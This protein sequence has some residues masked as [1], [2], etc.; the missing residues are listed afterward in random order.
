MLI[1]SVRAL[2]TCAAATSIALLQTAM[3]HN[4]LCGGQCHSQCCCHQFSY[5]HAAVLP[6]IAHEVQLRIR[7][8]CPASFQPQILLDLSQHQKES[9][10]MV[11][12]YPLLDA[13]VPPIVVASRVLE[14]FA[15]Q[16]RDTMTN[17]VPTT[18]LAAIRLDRYCFQALNRI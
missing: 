15:I 2:C 9:F 16:V 3:Q 8:I 6:M 17:I 13:R 10:P 5:S 7:V 11:V 14:I 4:Y 18:P 1:G 12:Q